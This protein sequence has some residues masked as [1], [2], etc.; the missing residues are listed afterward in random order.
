MPVGT[1]GKINISGDAQPYKARA[2]FRDWDGIVRPVVRF[3]QTKKAAEHA[4]LEALR[5]RKRAGQDG[6]I[7]AA[8]TIG[9]LA[10]T[11]LRDRAGEWAPNTAETYRYIVANQ[12]KPALGG[13]RLGELQ[14]ERVI[15]A[16]KKIADSNG[17]GAAKTARTVLAGMCDMAIANGVMESNPARGWRL[18]GARKVRKG[19]VRALT[20]DEADALCDQLRASPRAVE[21]DLPDLVEWMLGT[22]CRIGEACATRTGVV[23]VDAGTWE[24]NATVIRLRGQGLVVQ[25]WPKTGA[26]WRVLALPPFA[27]EMIRR[28]LGEARFQPEALRVLGEDRKLRTAADTAVGFPA[29]AA[30]NLRDPSNTAGDLREVLDMLGFDWV[31]SH[32]FRKTVATRLDEAGLTPRQIADQLG[33]AK[34]SM[35]QDV[36][37]GRKVVSAEAARLLDR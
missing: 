25:E 18:P 5:D 4:L 35:T 1:Y 12:V 24:V 9:S 26:G 30:R 17:P 2:R 7:T 8:T 22:G 11:Y 36:Y 19:T 20:P 23:D 37:M 29:A 33:H 28:R 3:G 21:L 13:I 32:V 10:D 14:P 27:V 6:H 16:L 34:P 15:R 31:T